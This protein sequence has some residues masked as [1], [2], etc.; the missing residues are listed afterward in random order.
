MTV[1]PKLCAVLAAAVVLP[2]AALSQLAVEAR[3]DHS[4]F[5]R[6]E[7]VVVHVRVRNDT[8]RMLILGGLRKE[9]L[10]EFDVFRGDQRIPRKSGSMIVE[11]VLLMPG[12]SRQIDVPLAAHYDLQR[13]GQYTI[14][15]A[16]E[17]ENERHS[18]K[19]LALDVVPGVEIESVVRPVQDQPSM[20]RTYSL[21]H[22][23]RESRSYLFLCVS[24]EEEAVSYGVFNLGPLLRFVRPELT[25]DV[26]G[27]VMVKHQSN[28][29]TFLYTTFR[30]T[31]DG[32]SFISQEA[33]QYEGVARMRARTD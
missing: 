20:M 2:S 28:K 22:W 8:S 14:A 12:E 25:V 16:V 9:A 32:I 30:S 27:N 29:D 10:L 26:S 15:A 31:V 19:T 33:G 13:A 17:G 3:L 7:P 5:L 4:S 23:N 11:N 1:G 21:R 6:F 24:G 18:S